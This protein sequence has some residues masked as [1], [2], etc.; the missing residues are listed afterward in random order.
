MTHTPSA[1]SLSRLFGRILLLFIGLLSL[2]PCLASGQEV[3]INEIMSSNSGFLADDD[4]DDTDWIELYNPADVCQSLSGCSLSDS[5]GTPDKW[6]FPDTVI[7]ARSFMLVFASGKDRTIAGRPL[8]TNFKID[9]DGEYVLLSR[10]GIVISQVDPVSLKSNTSYGARPD[11]S[12]TFVVFTNPTPGAPNGGDYL[13]DVVIFS[14]PGGRYG[15]VFSLTLSCRDASLRIRYTT[16]GR[17]PTDESTEY[18]GPLHM[19]STLW[20]T[21]NITSKR[22]C[23]PDLYIPPLGRQ[24]RAIVI[25][26]AA[27]DAEGRRVSDIVT[28]SYFIRALGI[29]HGKL[30]VVSVCSDPSGLFDDS[31][32]IMVPGIYWDK[33]NPHA[34]GN[35]YQRGLEWERNANI[36]FYEADGPGGFRHSVGLRVHGGHS[37]KLMQKNLAVY[38]RNDYGRNTIEYPLFSEKCVAGFRRL[39]L[40]GYSSSSSGCGMEN[41]LGGKLASTVDVDY[42]AGRPAVMYLNGEY[43]GVYFI[44]EKQDEHFIEGN[45]GICADS[46][47]LISDWTGWAEQG[48]NDNF[49]ALYSFM[50]SADLTSDSS[51]A[52][53][54]EWIDVDNFIDYQ[55]LEIFLAN[56][57]W[58]ANNVKMWRERKDGARWRWMYFDGDASMMIQDFDAFANALSTEVQPWP[59]NARSTL[60]LRTLLV[61]ESFRSRFFARL[62]HL[63][64][65]EF[66]FESTA[67]FF[68]GISLALSG[69][70]PR[71][72]Q[73]F[74]E[75]P[76]YTWWLHAIGNIFDFLRYRQCVVGRHVTEHF[77]LHLYLP[78]CPEGT[79]DVAPDVP[80]TD[81]VS[82]PYPNPST[83]L[84]TLEIANAVPQRVRIIVSDMLGRSVHTTEAEIFEGDKG[85]E[86][87]LGGLPSGPYMLRILGRSGQCCFRIFLTRGSA[88]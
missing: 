6:S 55:L 28:H 36:E 31:T 11:G 4:G 34:T 18:T 64:N 9:A 17:E 67:P 47:D 60:F 16:D 68:G 21:E 38:A 73:R 30:P 13:R 46:I 74:P 83:G 10:D 42:T 24:K 66:A 32:G 72:A 39:A 86:V 61:N 1:D 53:V 71:Q 29:D 88:R 23:P 63:L 54:S 80:V 69:E 8:H 2:F 77:G 37:R 75:V 22:L 5:R 50:E 70:I 84:I 26:A 19:D 51:M 12:G 62:E 44:C 56:W 20:S 48:S 27:F 41:H 59:T 40:R 76:S 82:G 57:D 35:Y 43:W 85:I 81:A 3:V 25:R 7:N 87:N 65:N 78:H 15:S 79:S 33:D 58:P 14:T 45:T 49:H 52:V